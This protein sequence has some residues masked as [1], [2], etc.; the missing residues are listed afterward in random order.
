MEAVDQIERVF[1]PIADAVTKFAQAESC[2]IEKCPRGN[3]G[4]ELTRPHH[5]GGTL[6][7][8]L[9]YDPSLG[10]GIGSVWQFPCPEMSLLYSHFRN[11]RP[12]ALT[13]DEA[14]MALKNAL[15]EIINVPFGYW[16]DITPLPPRT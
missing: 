4:W 3:S 11:L 8:L 7:L 16:T 5:L 2:Q 6:T 9:L 12:C 13:A 14:R 1:A 10:L 15:Q